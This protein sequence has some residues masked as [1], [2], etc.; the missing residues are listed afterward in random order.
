MLQ[1]NYFHEV[2]VHFSCACRVACRFM[3]DCGSEK[4][5]VE[6][7]RTRYRAELTAARRRLNMR[8]VKIDR[9]IDREI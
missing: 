2:F 6:R 5:R 7:L 1:S 8:K 4:K 9:E 3:L